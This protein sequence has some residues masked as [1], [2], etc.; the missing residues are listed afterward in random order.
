MRPLLWAGSHG[1]SVRFEDEDGQVAL[2]GH[3]DSCCCREREAERSCSQ[4]VAYTLA[5]ENGVQLDSVDW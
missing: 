5:H 1:Q 4:I 2:V 3:R